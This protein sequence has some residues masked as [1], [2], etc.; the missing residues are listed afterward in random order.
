MSGKIFIQCVAIVFFVQ[1]SCLPAQ[2]QEGRE[3]IVEEAELTVMIDS[4]VKLLERNYIDAAMGKEMGD[5]VRGHFEEGAYDELSLDS[6]SSKLR[7]DFLTVSEDVH[8]N[9][10]YRKHEKEPQASLLADKMNDYGE[11]SNYGYVDVKISKGNIGYLKVAHFTQWQFFEEAQKVITN[12]ISML[13]HTDGLIIDLRDNP[14]GFEDIVAYLMSYFFVEDSR[15]LQEYY[16][17]YLDRRRS[18]SL[19]P[20]LPGIKLPDLP[21]FILVNYNTGS[22]AE[23]FAYMMKHLERATVIGDTT[24][25]AGNGSTYFRI[26]DEIVIQIA[27]WETINAVTHTSWEKVG[28]VP[29]IT[30]S[31]EEAMPKA[32]VLVKAAS[33]KHRAEKLEY[34]RAQ[35][36]VLDEAFAQHKT[37]DSNDAIIDALTSCQKLK[38]FDESAINSL[39]YKYLLTEQN[40]AVAE[41]ILEANTLLYPHSA[42]VYDSFAEALVA[43]DKL[44]EAVQSYQKAVAVA[45]ENEDDSLDL[46]KENLAKLQAEVEEKP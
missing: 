6:L 12:S 28:V 20:D 43:N 22:A 29:N 14:G 10:F 18:V 45:E 4:I 27:T 36:E 9:A 46:F 15:E 41:A 7:E 44:K 8:M 40:P 19:S 37:G 39:G 21:I 13:Q 16:C 42:N 30:T 32:Q 33:Q 3:R 35:L 11:S 31:D 38:F 24:V 26:S 2:A 1:L 17:R 34:Y 25:G 5:F 23:S